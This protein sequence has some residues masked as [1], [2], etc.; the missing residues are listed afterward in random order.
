MW[1]FLIVDDDPKTAGVLFKYLN[2]NANAEVLTAPN[3]GMAERFFGVDNYQIHFIICGDVV[4]QED[5]SAC[6]T[7]ISQIRDQHPNIL[8]VVLMTDDGIPEQVIEGVDGV[9][10]RSEVLK[11]NPE[12][13]RLWDL[14]FFLDCHSVSANDVLEATQ[15]EQT[16]R[17]LLVIDDD[18]YMIVCIKRL[19]HKVQRSLNREMYFD[20]ILTAENEEQAREMLSTREITHVLTDLNLGRNKPKGYQVVSKLRRE[21]PCIQRAVM[22]TGGDGL[23]TNVLPRGIDA[24]FKKSDP[25][26]FIVASIIRE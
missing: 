14:L 11:A 3:T 9:F 8:G 22:F 24:I 6:S 10:Q 20:D 4:L 21:F 12:E 5:D 2:T 18:E 16:G 25:V 23:E 1:R 17:T 15:S 13:T 7:W 19:L 26:D